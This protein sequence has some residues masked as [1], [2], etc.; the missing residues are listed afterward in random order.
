MSRAPEWQA[1]V[2]TWRDV[3][4]TE[5]LQLADE[6]ERI[7]EMSHRGGSALKHNPDFAWVVQ[8]MDWSRTKR[9]YPGPVSEFKAGKLYEDIGR[10]F[11]P[12]LG[13]AYEKIEPFLHDV[14]GFVVAWHV[15][16]HAEGKFF[17]SRKNAQNKLSEL[18]GGPYA[19]RMYD[20]EM[21]VVSECGSMGARGWVMHYDCAKTL[22]LKREPIAEGHVSREGRPFHQ[23]EVIPFYFGDTWSVLRRHLAEELQ[24]CPG[25]VRLQLGSSR[26]V[27][28]DD[29]S[30]PH[31][32]QLVH[33][34][35]AGDDCK[36][37]IGSWPDGTE[38][39]KALKDLMVKLCLDIAWHESDEF[40]ALV[41][42]VNRLIWPPGTRSATASE[43]HIC[44]TLEVLEEAMQKPG[45]S[46]SSMFEYLKHELG[47]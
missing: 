21:E 4:N 29:L 43:A 26:G 44:V 13:D 18:S 33:V 46:I 45:T 9:L 31:D 19:A 1:L 42:L 39:Q 23:S 16:D 34:S 5:D 20:S 41:D 25:R 38:V 10:C 11:K 36:D 12:F 24:E 2:S 15:D 35:I 6:V 47:S 40:A 32:G 7:A 27:V 3:G 37:I 17:H 8:A 30:F 22:F 28:V 14:A